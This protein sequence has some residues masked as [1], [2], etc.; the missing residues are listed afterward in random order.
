MI[1]QTLWIRAGSGK[2]TRN[3]SLHFV[4]DELGFELCSVLPALHHLTGADYTSKV[5]TKLSALRISPENYLIGF[6]SSKFLF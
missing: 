1:L 6:G 3:I 4:A 5:G 2:T